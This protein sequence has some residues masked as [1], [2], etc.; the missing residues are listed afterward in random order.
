MF[1]FIG[2][3]PE[4][5]TPIMPEQAKDFI[6]ELRDIEEMYNFKMLNHKGLEDFLNE[7]GQRES[8][9]DPRAIN[10]YGYIGRFQF[11]KAALKD[12]GYE[13][14]SIEKFKSDTTIFTPEEQ[15]D[16]MIKYMKLNKRR[17]DKLI[18]KYNGKVING[19]KI[20]ESGIL[21]ASHLSGAGSVQKFL[22]S[23]GKYNPSD[24]YG[25]KLVDYLSKFS[26]HNFNLDYV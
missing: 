1:N 16:A 2:I 22:R 23:G 8:S 24:G 11:G 17:L 18:N 20:T 10:T 14:I 25:T 15:Y 7:I 5:R 6:K 26:K 19:I 3:I 4:D 12:V 9:N 21:A 13:H